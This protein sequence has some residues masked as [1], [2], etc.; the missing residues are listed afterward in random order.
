MTSRGDGNP[1]VDMV[2][3]PR[4]RMGPPPRSFAADA[5]DCIMVQILTDQPNT[6]LRREVRA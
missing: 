6:S 3:E 1:I 4:F 2:F 5:Y